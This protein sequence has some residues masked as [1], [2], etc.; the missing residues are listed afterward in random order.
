MTN[1]K[2][3][4]EVKVSVLEGI[5]VSY[6]NLTLKKISDVV[7]ACYQYVLKMSKKPVEGVVYD[8]KF[9]NYVEAEKVLLRKCGSL[10]DYD[11]EEIN[12][13]I[14]RY[15]PLNSLEE[16]NVGDKFRFRYDDKGIVRTVVYK[17]EYYMVSINNKDEKPQVQNFDT[18]LHQSPRLI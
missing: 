14:K 12:N 18:F 7:G 5:L 8:A 9:I 3:V 17:N 13:S 16:F 10:L 6:P 11:W 15:E 2:N 4:E 1:L